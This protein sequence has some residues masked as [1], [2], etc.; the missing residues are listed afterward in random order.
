MM[1]D[2]YTYRVQ[3]NIR[4]APTIGARLLTGFVV[5]L[6][7]PGPKKHREAAQEMSVC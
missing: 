5:R 2:K 6:G 1:R 7:L 4:Q 3:Y